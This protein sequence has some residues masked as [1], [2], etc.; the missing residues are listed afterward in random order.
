MILGKDDSSA[1]YYQFAKGLAEYRQV[2]LAQAVQWTRKALSQTGADYNRDVQAYSV[3]AMSL[4]RL[5]KADEAREAFSKA[6]ELAGA[7][8]PRIESG[9]LGPAWYDWIIAQTLLRESKVLIEGGSKAGN[10]T[11]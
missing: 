5:N 3:L 7:K 6:T 1:A 10:E 4:H 2:N 8:L 9:D 11:K